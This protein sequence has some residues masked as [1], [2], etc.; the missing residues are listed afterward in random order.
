MTTKTR[1]ELELFKSAIDITMKTHEK[2]YKLIKNNRFDTFEIQK[3]VEHTKDYYNLDYAF[4]PIISYNEKIPDLHYRHN[5]EKIPRD[6]IIL[7][8]IG[9][10]VGG[11]CSDITRCYNINN[12]TKNNLYIFAK[13]IQQYVQG[14]IKP[15]ISLSELE[16]LYIDEYIKNLIHLQILESNSIY[17]S[18]H[19][20]IAIKELF[21]P[22]T[23]GH[24]VG[25]DV[26]EKMNPNKKLTKGMVIT[27]E[28]GIYFDDNIENDLDSLGIIYNRKNLKLYKK[29]GGTR[30]EDMFLVTNYGC[31]KL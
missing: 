7:V 14:L 29:Y 6:S 19:I 22:H 10:K 26:H 16:Y 9:Y 3:I 24:S 31:E 27:I 28:P 4:T 15:G 2:I 25:K 20:K 12:N 8:D 18:E 17:L 11:Y 13:N 5:N 30:Y 21:Q 23:I 1:R